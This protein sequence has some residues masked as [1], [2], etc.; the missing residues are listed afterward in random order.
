[1]DRDKKGRW[2]VSKVVDRVLE[3]RNERTKKGLGER[4]KEEKEDRWRE[5]VWIFWMQWSI[6]FH[7][8][9]M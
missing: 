4:R 8:Q 5:K 7:I 3:W 9:D 1:M 6:H 2:K